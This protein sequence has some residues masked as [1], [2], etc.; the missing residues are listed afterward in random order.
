M[1]VRAYVLGL[2]L[3]VSVV[4]V[5]QLTKLYIPV[6]TTT[7]HM[8][9]LASILALIAIGILSRQ[10]RSYLARIAFVVVLAAGV[11]NIIDFARYGYVRDVFYVSALV[12]N[13]ADV[14]ILLGA[15]AFVV[16]IL[17]YPRMKRM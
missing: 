16:A 5:D 1:N 7:S 6:L 2:A 12:F 13:M 14:I 15:G 4:A 8:S 3:F 10:Y 11:S 17:A 9:L